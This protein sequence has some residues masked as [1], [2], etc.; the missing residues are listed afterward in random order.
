MEQSY[1]PERERDPNETLL[2]YTQEVSE[3]RQSNVLCANAFL[4]KLRDLLSPEQKRQL[5]QNAPPKSKDLV[6]DLTAH[7]LASMLRDEKY[8]E[9]YHRAQKLEGGPEKARLDAEIQK[10]ENV[11]QQVSDKKCTIEQMKQ[12]VKPFLTEEQ[13]NGP[14]F[15]PETYV[16]GL[17][18]RDYSDYVAES[19]A[20]MLTEEQMQELQTSV[21][22]YKLPWDRTHEEMGEKV[23]TAESE[24]AKAEIDSMENLSPEQKDE[25]KADIDAANDFLRNPI[26]EDPESAYMQLS[27]DYE[28]AA[29]R[30]GNDA[31]Q[32]QIAKEGLEP[33]IFDNTLNEG[34]LTEDITIKDGKEKEF[35][36][37][38]KQEFKFSPKTKESIKHVFGMMQKYGYGGKGVIGEEGTKQYGLSPLAGSIRAYKKAIAAGDPVEIAKASKAMMTEKK[39]LDEMLDYVKQNFPIDRHSDNFAKAGNID[40]VRN[41]TFPPDYRYNDAVSAFNSIFIMMNFAEANGMSPEEFLEHPSEGIRKY[42]YEGK[43]RTGLQPNLAGKTGGDAFFEASRTETAVRVFSSSG[44]G[45][46]YEAMYFLDM[47]PEICA[48]NHGL[49]NH[50]EKYAFEN[51]SLT[52]INRRSIAYKKGH[53][54][55]YLFVHEEMA[56][57]TILGLPL[58][59]SKTLSYDQPEEFNEADYLRNNGKSVTEMKEF[60]DENI[61]KY[62]LLKKTQTFLDKKGTVCEQSAYKDNAFVALVQQA[63]SK[64]LIAKYNEK[65]NGSYNALKS[66]LT[67]GE[68]YVN[69][70]MQEEKNKVIQAENALKKAEEAGNKDE[71]E[72]LKAYI[73]ANKAFKDITVKVTQPQTRYAQN[74]EAFENKIAQADP[75]KLAQSGNLK[76]DEDFNKSMAQLLDEQ[77]KL[78]QRFDARRLEVGQLKVDQDDEAQILSGL[79]D[80]KRN[81]IHQL[82]EAYIAQ[83]DKDVKEGRI[84][85]SFKDARIKQIN[86]PDYKFDTLPPF[87]QVPQTLSK[88]DYINSLVAAGEKLDDYDQADRDALYDVYVQAQNALRERDVAEYVAKN[89]AEELGFSNTGSAQEEKEIEQAPEVQE[90]EAVVEEEKVTDFTGRWFEPGTQPSKEAFVEKLELLDA[91]SKAPEVKGNNWLER[92]QSIE[93]ATNEVDRLRFF[94]EEA[95]QKLSSEGKQAVLESLDEASR[96]SAEREAKDRY[97]ELL[98]NKS[99]QA[100]ELTKTF[101]T[102]SFEDVKK[103]SE[104]FL[105]SEEKQDP[106]LTPHNNITAYNTSVFGN[107]KVWKV[108]VDNLSEEDFKDLAYRTEAHKA[109]LERSID[110]VKVKTYG[111]EFGEVKGIL[112]GMKY[113]KGEELTEAKRAEIEGKL[114]KAQDLLSALDKNYDSAL[115]Q[116]RMSREEY[117][118]GMNDVRSHTAEEILKSEGIEVHI[119]G[120]NETTVVFDGIKGQKTGYM[121]SEGDVEMDQVQEGYEE[122]YQKLQD[123]K[124]QMRQETKDAVK[125]IFAK[126]DE[127]G[128]DQGEFN[129]EEDGKI[130]GL[131]RYAKARGE[132][133]ATCFSSD[134]VEKI[135]SVEAAEKMITEYNRVQEI[136]GIAK[137]AFNL[138]KGGFY[139]G[140]MDVERNGAFPPEWRKDISGVSMLNGLYV[141]YRTLKQQDVNLDE[142][143]DDPR[144]YMNKE[145]RKVVDETDVNNT[146]KGKSGA[147]AITDIITP[148]QDRGTKEFYRIGRA[149]ETMSKLET[150]PEMARNNMASEY[151]YSVSGQFQLQAILYRDELPRL[152]NGFLDNYL[153]VKE[154]QQDASLLGFPTYDFNTMKARP[155]VDFDEIDY[156]WNLQ[157]T[158]DEYLDRILKEGG[159]TL[160]WMQKNQA[161][162]GV[163]KDTVAQMIQK[164]SLK[165]LVAH[166]ELDKRSDAYK[167]M[168]D[169]VEKGPEVIGER[170]HAMKEGKFA[171]ELEDLDLDRLDFESMEGA[172]PSITLS[173]FAKSRGMKNYGEDVRT[174]DK[175]ANREFSELQAQLNRAKAEMERAT[176]DFAVDKASQKRLELEGQLEKAIADRKEQLMKDFRSGR[177]TEHYLNKRNE[178]LDNGKFRDNLPKMFEADE[179][180]SKNVYLRNKYPDDF[181]SFGKNEKDELYKHYVDNAKLAKDQF[182]AKK[183]LETLGLRQQFEQKTMAERI[184]EKDAQLAMQAKAQ[185][186]QKAE[187]IANKGGVQKEEP[188][189]QNIHIELDEEPNLQQKAENNVEKVEVKTEEKVMDEGVERIDLDLDDNAEERNNDMLAIGDQKKLEVDPLKK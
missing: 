118:Y 41:P 3:S 106:R 153:I 18:M 173:Q 109:Q 115:G 105:T 143:L 125:A 171:D 6:R 17:F 77:A 64:I 112:Q 185:E 186:A 36:E 111:K 89:E 93:A 60:L 182:V 142:F 132:F 139:S 52:D 175:T 51:G 99:A 25:M 151:A 44:A 2:H 161:A 130:Y 91:Q 45:R 95:M 38:E 127:Y 72:R 12:I 42:I 34:T 155:R 189:V 57:A 146:L 61:K 16:N 181:A 62:L 79:I 1:A 166:P 94:Y 122:Q 76:P 96:K 40:V 179:L 85:G 28:K 172:Y 35:Q 123:R 47:D 157:E 46:A 84:V 178:Q 113:Y 26:G 183:Y 37:W 150:D 22:N 24:K 5:V 168:N 121:S 21:E 149:V 147:A 81:E 126:F 67:D 164:A 102:M 54:D 116:A 104:P 43:G 152:G 160:A 165:Y 74:L 136:I 7:T 174:A 128:F 19:V 82:K 154:P 129:P 48:H 148:Y 55:R 101:G 27:T 32:K 170:L 33:D 140:N 30:D 162:I 23:Y 107:P 86:D 75:Q 73:D 158:P 114:D 133:E 66:V 137:D 119:E 53:M 163:T 138:D 4:D 177:I 134:P 9:N 68:G 39:H 97:A 108:I 78:N 58:Y 11:I 131:Q 120:S 98:K 49:G 8:K 159:K 83:L 14:V 65:G 31:A 180:M 117:K 176:T 10:V 100:K 187:Q 169:I 69:A 87:F 188:K 156:L 88:E 50:L 144:A 71:I 63:A 92:R 141:M 20:K 15:K 103:A 90:A 145:T 80:Q 135:K 29:L 13:M 56:P 124:I 110:E 70:L 59:N 184:A 167:T